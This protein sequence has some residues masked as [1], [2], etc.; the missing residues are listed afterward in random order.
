MR[1]GFDFDNTIVSY[2]ALFHKVAMEQGA[3]DQTIPVNKLA[4]RDHLRA[5]DREPIWTEMQGYVYGARMDE[6][7][8]YPDA[9]KVMRRLKQV[10][11]TLV[12]VSH[13]TKYPY[14]GKQYDLHEAAR[15]WIEKHL[16]DEAG[17]LIPADHVF[18]E[19]TKEDKLSRIDQLDCDV[20]IDDLPEILLASLFPGKTR[21]YL[22]DPEQ[23]HMNA[24]LPDIKVVSSWPVFESYL[25]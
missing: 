6:A 20:F 19:I 2:D 16:R 10:G 21:R 17:R 1:I 15:S 9:L 13:K 7:Q 22:F 11:H 8:S 25:L 14:L 23:Y 3:I 24:H 12:I 5:T 18:F 4:V